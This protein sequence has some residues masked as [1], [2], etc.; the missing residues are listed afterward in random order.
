MLSCPKTSSDLEWQPADLASLER[1]QDSGHSPTKP[2][3]LPVKDG[4]LLEGDPRDQQMGGTVEI[5]MLPKEIEAAR[6]TFFPTVSM[7]SMKRENN[8]NE[9]STGNDPSRGPAQCRICFDGPDQ[10]L[11]RLIRPC[12]CKGSISVCLHA[13]YHQPHPAYPMSLLSPLLARPC[14]VLAEMENNLRF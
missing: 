1:P 10:E 14:Q 6:G 4:P 12:L 3:R 11:G 8:T 2:P 5:T 7:S 13:D 9:E